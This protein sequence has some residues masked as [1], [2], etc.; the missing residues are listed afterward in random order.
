LRKLLFFGTGAAIIGI[1]LLLVA[2]F[3]SYLIVSTLQK[4]FGESAINTSLLLED[5]TLEAVF[6]G[7]MAAIG[8]ALISKG[9]DGI[10]REQLLEAEGTAEVTYGRGQIQPRQDKSRYVARSLSDNAPAPPIKREQASD[11]HQ[12]I[13]QPTAQPNVTGQK[14]N[15]QSRAAAVQVTETKEQ[16]PAWEPAPQLSPIRQYPVVEKQASV[17]TPSIQESAEANHGP[18]PAFS[19]TGQAVVP[20]IS[21]PQANPTNLGESTEAITYGADSTLEPASPELNES[22]AAETGEGDSMVAQQ[23]RRRGRPRGSK[24]V[25]D[26]ST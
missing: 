18:M 13:K 6:L 17:S 3:E 7:I 2:F 21:A 24:N 26:E 22:Q 12:G 25:T 23:K 20:D 1:L 5:A 16:K 19:T 9:L 4:Q 10:R 14:T 8:Y 15:T 11:L